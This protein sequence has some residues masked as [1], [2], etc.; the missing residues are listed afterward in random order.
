VTQRNLPVHPVKVPAVR[1][2]NHIDDIASPPALMTTD[3]PS[4]IAAPVTAAGHVRRA[5]DPDHMTGIAGEVPPVTEEVIP[6]IEATEGVQE[7]ENL[8]AAA[9]G[10]GAGHIAPGTAVEQLPGTEKDEAALEKAQKSTFQKLKSLLVKVQK[11][12]EALQN[13]STGGMRKRKRKLL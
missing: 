4:H 9:A 6:G 8:T 12:L 2:T 5:D 1:N 3:I 13:L 11:S 7:R 10:Q